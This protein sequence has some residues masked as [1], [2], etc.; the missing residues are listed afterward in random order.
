MTTKSK[1]DKLKVT[2]F[3]MDMTSVWCAGKHFQNLGGEI[4]CLAGG[5]PTEEEIAAVEAHF[6]AKRKQ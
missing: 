5:A 1:Q 6:E 2:D 4:I 3:K